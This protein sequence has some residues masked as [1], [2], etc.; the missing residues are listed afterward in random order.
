MTILTSPALAE[1]PS[2]LPAAERR[3]PTPA[4][5][6]AA[7]GIAGIK[8]SGRPDLAIIATLTEPDGKRPRAAA[9]AVYTPNA[10]AAAPVRLSKAHLAATD[11]AGSGRFGWAAAVISTSGCANAATGAVGD[12]DQAAVAGYLCTAVGAPGEDAPLLSR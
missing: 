9:A 5:F 2:D 1:L 6:A 8:A 11:P 7:S 3:A 4:G 10:F 12:T